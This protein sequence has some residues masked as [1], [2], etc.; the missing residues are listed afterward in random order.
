MMLFFNSVFGMLLALG[1]LVTVH[2]Y[3]HFWMAR[4]FGVKVERF[5]VGFGRPIWRKTDRFG[6]EFVVAWIP[7][8]GY[9][10]MLDER[11]GPVPTEL[12]GQTFNSKTAR[13]KIAIALAGPMTNFLFAI[14]AFALMYSIGVQ[15]LVPLIDHPRDDSPAQQAD[16]T[17]GDRILAI[18]GRSVDSF[19]DLSLALASRV[20]ES[21][22]IDIS[23]LRQ[24]SKKNVQ[25]PIE[26]WLAEQDSPD[27]LRNLGLGPQM[28]IHPALIGWI[29][30]GGPAEQSG[31]AVGDRVLTIDGSAI[32]TWS[33]WVDLV[34]NS[35]GKVLS[36]SVK[37][38]EQT[39]QLTLVPGTKM[40]DERT[41]GFVGTGSAPLAWSEQQ[42]TT[43]RLWP[44]QAAWRGV[45]DT[46][47]MSVLSY[48]MLWKMA[49]GKVSL[50]Q[51]G[52]PI[53]MAKMAGLS[54]GSG[55]ESFIGFLA[56][57]S[58]S[59]AIVNLLPIPVLDGGHVVIH[60]I[61]W[62]RGKALSDRAQIIGTQI[63]MVFILSLMLLTFYNDIGR[64]M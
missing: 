11:E 34:Q 18:D 35:P 23:L 1:I 48:N 60:S 37:R 5:S 8:G 16:M 7:L 27:P 31:L 30:A 43:V 6:T 15:D 24:Q 25:L 39:L 57:I 53:S 38:A 59:L 61:E 12:L 28:P 62:L 52:G 56:L 22:I 3:G 32:E 64:L 40:Q 20:G 26:N 55:F 54:V 45:T 9:V 29:E 21:G 41:I 47:Q 49:T 2:E 44:W 17:R 33:E 51:I 63:G 42:L 36:L 13:Q 10:K 19:T 58:I 46:V 50:K 4:R 14:V